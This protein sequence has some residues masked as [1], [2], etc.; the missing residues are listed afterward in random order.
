MKN[1]R[2][3]SRCCFDDVKNLWFGQSWNEK[4]EALVSGMLS[5]DQN[6]EFKSCNML[7]VEKTALL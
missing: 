7:H 2:K 5:L 3:K 6:Y 4:I 1:W